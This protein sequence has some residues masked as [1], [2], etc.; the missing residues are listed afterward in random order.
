IAEKAILIFELTYFKA[1]TI[2][3]FDNSSSYCTYALDAFNAKAMN[4]N[5]SR[6]N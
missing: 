4:V 1:I 6:K 2:F 3:V 5:P